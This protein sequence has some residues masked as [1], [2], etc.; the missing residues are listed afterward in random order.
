MTLLELRTLCRANLDEASAE[1]YSDALLTFWINSAERDIAAKTGCIESIQALSTT[2][3][4]RLV[5]FTGD[6]VTDIELYTSGTYSFIPGTGVQWQDTADTAW[7]DLSSVAWEDTVKTL[8]VPYPA[9]G[10]VRVTPHNLGH[11]S[12]RGETSPQYW[13]QWGNYIVIEPTPDAIYVLNAYTTQSPYRDMVADA[14][15]PEIPYEFQDAI[16][17]YVTYMGKLRARKYGDATAKYGEYIYT[18]QT[19]VDK[20]IHRTPA[21]MKDIRVPDLVKVR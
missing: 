10:N 17:L 15:E 6:K 3:G 1:F 14:E 12:L 19:L 16:P 4:S 21:R 11:I 2:N 13:F 7:Q 9:V 20:Y 18:L 8:Y 5:A